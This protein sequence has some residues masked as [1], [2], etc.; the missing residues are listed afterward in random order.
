MPNR[1]AMLEMI[2]SVGGL[3]VLNHCSGGG[4]TP[5]TSATAGATTATATPTPAASAGLNATPTASAIASAKASAS[6]SPTAVATATA[7]AGTTTSSCATTPE[8][9]IGPYFADDSASGFNRSNVVA[10]IDG[11][12]AQ[13]GVPLTLDIYVVDTE[14]NCAAY[15]GAQVDIWHCNAL[16]VYSD[17]SSENTSG[18]T[19]LRG[20]QLTN[21]AGYVQFV[22]IIPGWYGGRT[23]HIHLRVRST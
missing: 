4:S 3:F 23:N 6:A 5:S 20:Y 22:T 19:Y 14:K 12:S 2:G 7:T 17:I 18:Q 16:G 10:N 8:G 9:E 15:V 21:S 11:T 1:K 13:S